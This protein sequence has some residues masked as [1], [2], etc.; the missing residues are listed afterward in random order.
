MAK[1]GDDKGLAR[2]DQKSLHMVSGFEQAETITFATAINLLSG[3]FTGNSRDRKDF[4]CRACHNY[5]ASDATV[6]VTD[7][8]GESLT[9]LVKSGVSQ[10]FWVNAVSIDTGTTV[11]DT[12]LLWYHD[13]G[14]V[15][16]I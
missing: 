16:V 6:I 11:D 12:L 9:F 14:V 2:A 3:S 5:G 13:K 7:D 1:V 8:T 4:S 15:T 10:Q